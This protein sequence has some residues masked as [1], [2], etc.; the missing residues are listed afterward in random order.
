MNFIIQAKSTIFEKKTVEKN[1]L[2][3]YLIGRLGAKEWENSEEQKEYINFSWVK[4]QHVKLSD[5]NEF[6]ILGRGGFG[7]VKGVRHSK[8]GKV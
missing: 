1:A 7:L 6:R 2:G 8:S 3:Q 4:K 5:F